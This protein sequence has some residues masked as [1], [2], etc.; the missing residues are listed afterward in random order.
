MIIKLAVLSLIAIFTISAKEILLN[1]RNFRIA[2]TN[3][4][5]NPYTSYLKI[6]I[7]IF[8]YLGLT[9]FMFGKLQTL[10]EMN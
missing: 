2:K 6:F 10:N 4:F 7:T 5:Y 1:K 8:M 9:I 3:I